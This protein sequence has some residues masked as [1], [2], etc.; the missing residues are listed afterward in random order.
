MPRC[1]LAS[2]TLL[3]LG[4]HGGLVAGS[5]IAAGRI[6][7]HQIP[8]MGPVYRGLC[9]NFPALPAFKAGI[10]HRKKF[11]G[12]FAGPFLRM[13]SACAEDLSKP[14]V[15]RRHRQIITPATARHVGDER[16][17]VSE[18]SPF[19]PCP[20]QPHGGCDR[21]HHG[22]ENEASANACDSEPGCSFTSAYDT[23]LGG[24]A[25]RTIVIGACAWRR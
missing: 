11:R 10:C 13:P 15:H 9:G 20:G 8:T 17:A 19:E 3:S 16:A 4:T 1:Q 23:R 24:A 21:G 12:H 2:S 7:T 25:C 5:G 22:N 6:Y 18:P 14:K